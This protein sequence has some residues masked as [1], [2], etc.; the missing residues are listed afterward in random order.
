MREEKRIRARKGTP[1]YRKNMKGLRNSVTLAMD[2]IP[3]MMT[4]QVRIASPR[5]VI[6]G[7]SPNCVFKARAMELDW[8]VVVEN[9]GLQPMKKAN[10]AASQGSFSP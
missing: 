1:T 4:I 2:L 10:M 7:V 3:P 6:Q 9:I 8:M 5:P